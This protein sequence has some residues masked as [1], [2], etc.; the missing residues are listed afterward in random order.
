MTMQEWFDAYGVSHQNPVNKAVH[1]IC[2]PAI[3]FSIIGLL[4]SIPHGFLSDLVPLELQGYV[5]FGTLLIA[6]G[7]LFF[8]RLSI[9]ITLG[10]L[11][12]SALILLGQVQL[13]QVDWA[14]LWAINL[15]IFVAAWIGQFIGHNVEGAKPSFFDDLKFLLIGPAWLLHFIYRKVGIP[16]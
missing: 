14:P 15:G 16:Y 5:H 4:A 10:M 1:W 2:V 7:I 11:L 6:F 9:T 3:F 13:M 12:V 8:L